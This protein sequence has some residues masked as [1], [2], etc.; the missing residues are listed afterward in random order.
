MACFRF[1]HGFRFGLTESLSFSHGFR[2]GLSEP[3]VSAVPKSF[4]HGYK[5]DLSAGVDLEHGFTFIMIPESVWN[6][7]VVPDESRR[8][9]KDFGYEVTLYNNGT[10]YDL[11]PWCF[12]GQLV[13]RLS[14]PASFSLD[15]AD[16]ENRI[17]RPKQTPSDDFYRAFDGA[18][19]DDDWDIQKYIEI[20]FYAAGSYWYSPHLLPTDC[21]WGL[22]ATG[23][24]V[25]RVSGTDL[26]EILLQEDQQLE[27][28]YSSGD[29]GDSSAGQIYTSAGIMSNIAS[30]YGIKIRNTC[31]SFKVRQFSPKGVTGLDYFKQLIYVT[32]GQFYWDRDTLI[33][34]D[35]KWTQNGY[36]KWNFVDTKDIMNISYK[37]SISELKNEFVIEKVEKAGVPLAHVVVEKYGKTDF[38][39]LTPPSE[40]VDIKVL[41]A[42][43]GG[44]NLFTYYDAQ[45][46]PLLTTAGILRHG[47]KAKYV[48]FNYYPVEKEG[49]PLSTAMVGH[50]AN[51]RPPRA[52]VEFWG[53]QRPTGFG[54]LEDTGFKIWYRAPN[55]SRFGRRR[56]RT[57]ISNPL[58]PDKA[59]AI[60][61]ARKMA[62][63][64]E[65]MT[66]ISNWTGILNPWITP[67][68]TIGIE[69]GQ[70]GFE[71]RTNFYVES[72]T[73]KFSASG[74]FTM[75]LECSGNQV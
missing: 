58:I 67:G 23:D 7:Y 47:K 51:G 4:S 5:F 1:E 40:Y 21:Q 36:S 3:G 38:I 44:V 37:Q 53:M 59:H 57:P 66:M 62:E 52:E 70:A 60:A 12:N 41:D 49:V 28:Y 71:D 54:S 42:N 18:T 13:Q 50:Y 2:F 63:I 69:C 14:V 56:D 61:L 73:K 20:K 17:F 31:P 34:E 68:I 15:L 72:V 26:S 30:I 11:T 74:E 6:V 25:L 48:R 64:S 39:E 27:D 16:D 24:K 9:R 33:L 29:E 43:Y 8:Y 65:R 35:Q 45:Q 32:Q 55:Q 22:D 46:N 75:D 10:S 19:F